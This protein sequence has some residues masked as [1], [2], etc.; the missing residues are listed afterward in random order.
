MLSFPTAVSFPCQVDMWNVSVRE[1]TMGPARCCEPLEE[2]WCDDPLALVTSCENAWP[3]ATRIMMSSGEMHCARESA[4]SQ[5]RCTSRKTDHDLRLYDEEVIE[6]R[7][8]YAERR[9]EHDR[10]GR[11]ERGALNLFRLSARVNV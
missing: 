10:E 3:R 11:V 9:D 5:V 7:V 2:K 8:V 6:D 4:W 1:L